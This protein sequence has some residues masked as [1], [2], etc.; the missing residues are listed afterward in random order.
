MFVK[1]LIRAILGILFVIFCLQLFEQNN[2]HANVF[3][4]NSQSED[5]IGIDTTWDPY[6]II[7]K[8]NG[9]WTSHWISGNG[10]YTGAY[11]AML[12]LKDQNGNKSVKWIEQSTKSVIFNLNVTAQNV[13]GTVDATGHPAAANVSVTDPTTGWTLNSDNTANGWA[14]FGGADGSNSNGAATNDGG[15]F[16]FGSQVGLSCWYGV[17]YGTLTNKNQ[18]K[19]SGLNASKTYTV[20]ILSSLSSTS[21]APTNDTTQVQVTGINASAWTSIYQINNTSK[22]LTFTM[23]PFNPGGANTPYITISLDATGTTSTKYFVINAIKITENSGSFPII[24]TVATGK[25]MKVN[26][27]NVAQNVSGWDDYVFGSWQR[28][29]V[30]SISDATTGWRMVRQGGT[31]WTTSTYGAE[32]TRISTPDAGGWAFNTESVDTTQ[33]YNFKGVLDSSLH[34]STPLQSS[35]YIKNLDTSKYYKL[36]ILSSYA[37]RVPPFGPDTIK[38][39]YFLISNQTSVLNNPASNIINPTIYSQMFIGNTS[40]LITTLYIKP[41]A[42]YSNGIYI[43]FGGYGADEANQYGVINAMTITEYKLQSN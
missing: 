34:Y 29:Q 16:A 33:W 32:G 17:A 28:Y 36:Q 10:A 21:G 30:D 2:C 9:N 42:N 31:S 3:V 23:Q 1:R 8:V 11:P 7:N 39:S 12:V 25:V 27:T 20:Q 43:I 35:F 41:S 24:D 18:I 5:N 4:F 19:I 37:G 40:N 14:L 13:P 38:Y 15:G 6:M 26:F 22:L